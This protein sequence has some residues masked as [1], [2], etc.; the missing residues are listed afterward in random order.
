MSRVYELHMVIYAQYHNLQIDILIYTTL[1][2]ASNNNNNFRDDNIEKWIDKC[3]ENNSLVV[4]QCQFLDIDT[5]S[6][7]STSNVAIS[8]RY[9]SRHFISVAVRQ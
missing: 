2:Q 8:D 9:Q 4:E 7:L 6:I 5:V 1:Q 3:T